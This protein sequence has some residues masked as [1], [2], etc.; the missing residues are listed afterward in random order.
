MFGERLQRLGLRLCWEHLLLPDLFAQLLWSRFGPM[1]TFRHFGSPCQKKWLLMI[2]H[3]LV[4]ILEPRQRREVLGVI[5]CLDWHLLT[6]FHWDCDALS[7]SESGLRWHVALSRCGMPSGS[8][9]EALMVAGLYTFG[10]N[11]NGLLLSNY[12]GTD[13]DACMNRL[14]GCFDST[15][16]YPSI[17]FNYFQL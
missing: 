3:F 12:A 14:K 7:P 10:G 5:V 16:C 17:F 15:D 13:L 4:L 11:V 9:L 1:H 8:Q 2:T 6:S